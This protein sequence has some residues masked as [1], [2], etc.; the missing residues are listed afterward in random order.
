MMKC[1]VKQNPMFQEI[2]MAQKKIRS[3]STRKDPNVREISA[4]S[5]EHPGQ[6]NYK[7]R[8]KKLSENLAGDNKRPTES[9]Q[10]PVAVGKI[11]GESGK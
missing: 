6:S 9:N 3:T 2:H 5:K 8:P 1:K 4:G 10:N 7:P 11:R